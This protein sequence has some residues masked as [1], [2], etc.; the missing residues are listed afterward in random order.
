MCA[1]TR[2]NF[3]QKSNPSSLKSNTKDQAEDFKIIAKLKNIF[4]F[5]QILLCTSGRPGT[6]YVD[7]LALN[8]EKPTCLYHPRVLG[9]KV[10]APTAV[11]LI[12]TLCVCLCLCLM[13]TGACKDQRKMLGLLEVEWEAAVSCL[14]W[15]MGTE[16]G[17]LEEH[18]VI[19][20]A[21][22]LSSSAVKYFQRLEQFCH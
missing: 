1:I 22:H 4:V 2:E 11:T 5:T 21:Q 15:I 17:F 19:L 20:T 16:S 14:I 9:L 18:Q 8:S 7:L 13:Y 12:F 10:C 3:C 6:H